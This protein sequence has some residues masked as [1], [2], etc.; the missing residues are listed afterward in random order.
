MTLEPGRAV[1]FRYIVT[2]ADTAAALGSGELPVLGTPQVLALAERATVA[3]VAGAL[4]PGTTT[5]GTRV[6]LDHLAASPVG[7]ELEVEAVLERVAGRRL[8]FAVRLGD[9]DRLVANGRDDA[10]GG[11]HRRLPPPGRRRGGQVS[12]LR[13]VAERAVGA[14]AE[15][16]YRLI[17]DFDRHHPRFLPSAFSEFR[18]EEGGVGAGT[19]HSFRMTAGGRA[20]SFR[21]RVAEPEPGR[22][23]TES[24]EHSVDGDDL[25]CDPGRAGM[26]GAGGDA[27]AGRG[28]DR[29]VVRATVRAA[30]AAAVVCRG[31]GAAGPLRPHG[32][33][34][35][36]G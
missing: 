5:V 17:A 15:Q 2:G 12:E 26:P 25:G 4:E 28:R 33:A 9:G 23:L 3:A 13:V 20:R 34:R 1:A 18:V 7:A 30:G 6:E 21:M 31:A 35:L 24:D 8:Q 16:V 22:V 11:G 10:G 29:R 14:P 32:A 19:V 27:L 36:S